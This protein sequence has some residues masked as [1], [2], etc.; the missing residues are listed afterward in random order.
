MSKQNSEIEHLLDL[1]DRGDRR[2]FKSFYSELLETKV[3]IPL[4]PKPHNEEDSKFLKTNEQL[5][6]VKHEGKTFVPVFSNFEYMVNW[7]GEE[8]PTA[9]KTFKSLIWLLGPNTYVYL[10]SGCE[11]GKEISPWEIEKLQEGEE[12]LDEL[13]DEIFGEQVV[14]IEVNQTTGQFP[15]LC[16]NL[17]VLFEAYEAVNEAF[18]ISTRSS[19]DEPWRPLIG[20]KQNLEDQKAKQL[21]EEIIEHAEKLMEC[22]QAVEVVIDI[23][24]S[25]NTHSSLFHDARPFYIKQKKLSKKSGFSLSSLFSTKSEQ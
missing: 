5:V 8:A 13:V 18:I 15:E 19:E 2:A 16:K 22:T 6:I 12:V 7:C 10:N 25:R 1:A 20:L 23:E 14:E 21:E 3:Y 4:S 11:I 17:T 9:E 24:D